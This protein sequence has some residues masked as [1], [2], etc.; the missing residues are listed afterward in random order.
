M[1][2]YRFLYFKF[3]EGRKDSCSI[4]FNFIP[5]LTKTKFNCKPIYLTNTDTDNYKLFITVASFFISSS[6]A[7]NEQ[8]PIS[9]E[10]AAKS[11]SANKGTCP[12]NS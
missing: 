7:P 6:D 2:D 1:K 12:N 10:K 8:S 3:S 9:W 4:C 11:G 5:L